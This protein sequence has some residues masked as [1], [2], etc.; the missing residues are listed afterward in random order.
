MVELVLEHVPA[1]RAVAVLDVGGGADRLWTKLSG[2][3]RPSGILVCA[4]AYDGAY[5]RRVRALRRVLRRLRSAPV[6][7]L[8]HAAARLAYGRTLDDDR[9]RERTE[10]MYIPPEQ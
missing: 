5:N 7:A 6:E 8:V 1:D 4:M 3:L 2:E 9:L 10:Y